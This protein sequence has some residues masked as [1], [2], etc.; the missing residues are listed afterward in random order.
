M[1]FSIMSINYSAE[2]KKIFKISFALKSQN[3]QT[4]ELDAQHQSNSAYDKG[5]G[6]EA[7]SICYGQGHASIKRTR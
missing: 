5:V 1:V 6:R 4:D 3:P 2:M 7:K